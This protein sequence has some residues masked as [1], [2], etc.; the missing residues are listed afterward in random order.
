MVG[1]IEYGRAR[2]PLILW[3]VPALVLVVHV[4]V[5]V[6][7]LGDPQSISWSNIIMCCAVS[8]GIDQVSVEDA[9]FLKVLDSFPFPPTPLLT[10][11]SILFFFFSFFSEMSN[12]QECYNSNLMQM[13]LVIIE[14]K[15]FYSWLTKKAHAETSET[16]SRSSMDK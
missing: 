6:N 10:F 14:N 7:I 9:P 3:T 8:S 13:C 5:W 4:R 11:R 12:P 1:V 16:Q 2:N 15:L